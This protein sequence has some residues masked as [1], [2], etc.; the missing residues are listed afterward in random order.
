MGVVVSTDAPTSPFFLT[1]GIIGFLSFAFTFGT[2]FKVVWT[3]LETMTEAPHEVHTYLTNLRQELLEEK[4]SIR[5]MRKGMRSHYKACRREDREDLSGIELDEVM[6]KTM[7]DSI[8]RLCR[9]FAELER[10]FLE[11]GEAGISD[12]INHRKS[13]RRRRND[14]S[15]AP[16]YSSH[17]AYASPP[18]K[19]RT[20]SEYDRDDNLAVDKDEQDDAFWA[21]RTNYASYTLGRRMKWLR[22]KAQAQ[23]LF[24]TLSRVQIR[25]I[26]RQV[27]GMAMC[28]HEYGQRT[29]ELG[30]TT[31]NIDERI[32]R[33]VGVRRVE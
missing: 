29:V 7:S 21:Q 30:E 1:S 5:I 26:A 23:Q 6:L 18:E 10:P 8:K 9:Q 12:A 14:S 2:F 28:M 17:G 16:R 25:R 33:V 4:H 20:R 32:N 11:K 27:G 24:E 22:R 31:H 3:N 13:S 19:S 15:D